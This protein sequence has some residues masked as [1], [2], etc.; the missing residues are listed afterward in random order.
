MLKKIKQLI[1]H[2]FPIRLWYHRLTAIAAS[3]QYSFPARAMTAIGVT[4]TDGKTTTTYI[5]TQLLHFLGVPVGM[6][7]TVGFQILDTYETNYSHKTTLGRFGLQRMLARMKT[8]GVKTAVLEV[9]SHALDQGRVWGIPF[10]VAVFTN[11]SRE[12]LDYHGTMERY[13]FAK[14]MLFEKVAHHKNSTFVCN[15]DDSYTPRIFE[16]PAT[17]KI[18]YTLEKNIQWIDKKDTTYI[19]AENIRNTAQGQEF[20]LCMKE[21]RIE[22]TTALIGTFNIANILAAVGVAVSQGYTLERIASYIPQLRAVPGRMEE[23]R[24]RTPGKVFIDY[25][26]T[27][28]ALEKCY[29]TLRS[30][31]PGKLIAVLGACGDRD[32]GKRGDMG[33]IATTHCDHVIFTDEEAYEENAQDIIAMLVQG[34]KDASMENYEVCEDRAEALKRGLKILQEGD[35]L[36]V[37]GMGDQHSRVVQGLQ[38]PWSERDELVNASEKI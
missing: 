35:T 33:K 22:M 23:V 25:A 4:G 17:S 31:T 37:T 15:G 2:H 28:E 14:R 36:I 20:T 1:P 24:V 10:S 9:S 34:A 16:I 6:T 38:I 5:T 12:H 29:S 18:V 7:T 13:F 19:W 21:K 11:L 26:V 32:K 8:S 3:L 27:P 30:T